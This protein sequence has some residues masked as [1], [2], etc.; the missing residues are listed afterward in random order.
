MKRT[1]L[2]LLLFGCNDEQHQI[3]QPD[4]THASTDTPVIWFEDVAQNIG[5]NFNYH[6]GDNGNFY[7][8]ETMGGGVALF[9]YDNDSD[10]DLYLTQGN[11]LA[12]DLDPTL[13]NKLFEN[14]GTGIFKD[15]TL[16]SG[17]GDSSYSLGVATG[18]YNNDGFVDLY[19]TNYGRNTLLKNNQD[20][21]FEDVT[22]YAGVGDKSFS[23]CA[24]FVDIDNDDDL[25][26]FVTNYL[27]WSAEDEIDCFSQLTRRDY[28]APEAYRSPISDSLYLNNGDGT[29]T[30]ISSQSNI[31]SK[32]GTGL[33]I[34]I[35]D[36]SNDGFADIFVAN[37]GMQDQLW[38]NQGDNTFIDQALLYGCSVDNTG[39]SKASMG[40]ALSDID[41]DGDLDLY[42]TTLFQETDSF[43]INSQ[44]SMIDSTS[45]WGVA[46]DTR[47]YTGWSIILND[48]NN[49]GQ[50][51]LYETT[52]RVRW[53][54]DQFD[55]ADWLAEPNLLFTLEGE[56]FKLIEPL[57][58]TSEPL[59][60][61]AHGAATGDINKDG[62]LDI[63]IVNKDR[64]VNVL[65]N[66]LSEEGQNNWIRLDIRNKF[67]S[68][69]L[70]AIAEITLPNQNKYYKLVQSSTGY[71]SSQDPA[72]HIGLGDAT[73]ISD[74]KITW[75]NGVTKTLGTLKASQTHIIYP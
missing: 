13:T 63:I 22:S 39:K 10:L 2:C 61:T 9:D 19:I 75:Q 20:G 58:G 33:G 3:S 72:I 30:D 45:R 27:D 32:K 56:K 29:F 52:G 54:A 41:N 25:D 5:I 64:N 66:I 48:F 26:L 71:A 62:F 8:I 31:S 51:D 16:K 42:V 47:V 44:G 28:C 14:D 50:V 57:G 23:A 73:E 24:A 15:V 12:A 70:G 7:I 43:F 68:P 69:A 46:A 49:D 36:F 38:I 11:N 4:V 37:D 18:D 67:G 34:G 40:V 59:V 65:Q 21:T 17:S 1:V 35:G 74:L 60:Y 55:D 6:S 53:Q